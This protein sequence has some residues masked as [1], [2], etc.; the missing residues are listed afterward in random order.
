MLSKGDIV[1]DV[2]YLGHKL[3]RDGFT[4]NAVGGGR[5]SL[6]VMVHFFGPGTLEVKHCDL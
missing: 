3:E 4:G 2:S 6:D 1:S 5:A